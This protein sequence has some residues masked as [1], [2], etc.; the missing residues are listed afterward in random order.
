[1][2]TLSD[3]EALARAATNA[4]PSD[5]GLLSSVK[6]AIWTDALDALNAA[7]SPE[8]VLALLA[9]VRAA[10]ELIA[11]SD[12]SCDARTTDDVSAMVRFGKADHAVRD[13][14]AQ[15]EALP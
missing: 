5:H 6:V 11:A 13:A 2:T 7:L 9:V 15:L 14:L 8:R 4:E 12:H 10:S 3:L 1:M